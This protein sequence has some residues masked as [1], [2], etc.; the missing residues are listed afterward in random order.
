MKRLY[1]RFRQIWCWDTEF[2]PVPGWRV[3]P[4]CLAATEIKTSQSVVL[5]VNEDQRPN[6]PLNFGPDSLHVVYSATAELGFALALGWPLPYNVLDLWVERRNLTNGHTDCAGNPV[7]TDLVTTCHSYGIYDT[8]SIENK[9]AMRDCILQG[10]PFTPEETNKVLDYCRGDVKMLQDLLA[11]MLPEIVNLDQS[12]HRGRCMRA[13][14]CLE[15]NGVPVDVKTLEL[16]KR[17]TKTVRKSVVHIF[18]DEHNTGIHTFDKHGDPHFNR[19][20]YTDWINRLGFTEKTWPHGNDGIASADDKYVLEPTA[21][22][23]A[24]RLPVLDEYRQLR[25]FMTLAKS[26]FKFAVGPDARNRTQMRPFTA[27]SSRSQPETSLN[28]SNTAKALRS[29]LAPHRGEVLLHRDW[30]NAEYGIAAALAGDK[31]RWENYLYR[32][33]YLVEAADYGYCDYTATKETHRELRNRFKPVVLAGQYGQTAKG[34]AQVL[35][36][37]VKQAA[38]FQERKAKLYPVYQSWLAANEEDRI[39][40]GYVETEFGW[41]LWIPRKPTQHEIRRA[42]NLYMQGGC[43]EIMRYAA[44]LATERGVDVGASV[45]DAF[46]YTAPADS[47]EDV[48]AMMKSCMNEACEAV[49]GD[50][51]ALKSDRDVVL[52]NADGYRYDAGA[53]IHYGHYAHEDG[54]KTWNKIEDATHEAAEKGDDCE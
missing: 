29:L 54:I 31:K 36:I 12:L 41:R 32:D 25:K 38:A 42:M 3:K 37:T 1:E 50:G 21:T 17:H 4:V 34:L 24:D 27:V 13:Q 45:H 23:Y 26:E 43:A 15:H 48:D 49:L 2:I 5:W 14:A 22:L 46:F 28:I 9:E 35:D 33:A 40:N 16:L 11:M 18:E 47:W 39:F 10:P 30:S 52:Y 8:I 44:C 53:K 19:R 20:G 51:Y 6:N 7:P